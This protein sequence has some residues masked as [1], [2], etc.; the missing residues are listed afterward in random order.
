MFLRLPRGIGISDIV[1]PWYVS[2]ST[3]YPIHIILSDKVI[4]LGP[5]ILSSPL[6]LYPKFNEYIS[7]YE[8]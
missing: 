6:S 8:R 5:K 7:S 1:V 4:Y 2:P 3:V